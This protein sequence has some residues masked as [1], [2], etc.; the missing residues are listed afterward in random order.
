MFKFCPI[1]Q[2]KSIDCHQ[3]PLIQCKQCDFSYFH[4]CA[5]AVAG[6]ICCNNQVLFNVR[7]QQPALGC[8][9][10]PGGFVDYG[11]SLEQAI[12]REIKEE[13]N[14]DI[15]NWQYYCSQPN[16]YEYKNITYKT[17]D[18]IFISELTN[19]PEITLQEEEV[20]DFIWIDIAKI[21]V[22]KIGFESIKKAIQM[23]CD[24]QKSN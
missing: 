16:T 21:D 22:S 6:I 5:S 12:S 2:S 24:K 4:N 18:A 1:C 15:I 10:L 19:K 20:S 7:A 3:L 17:T 11:E 14:L 13:L 8:L 23:F 9:D